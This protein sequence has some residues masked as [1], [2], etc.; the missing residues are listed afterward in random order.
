MYVEGNKKIL[1]TNAISIIGSRSCSEEGWKTARRFAKELVGQNITIVS[2]MALGID[3]AAHRGALEGNGITIAV[4]GGGFKHI[5]PPENV[6]LFHQIIENGGAVITE[7]SPNT[8]T[9]SEYFLARNRIVSGLSLGTLVVEAAHRS[10]TSVTA[11]IAKR[12]GRKVFCLPHERENKHGVR[13]QSF[14][15]KRRNYSNSGKRYY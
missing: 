1:N 3:S 8:Y 5:Y 14:I 9:K 15:K 4:L 11:K 7:Y 10:G 13:N 6:E 2:G 12:Q